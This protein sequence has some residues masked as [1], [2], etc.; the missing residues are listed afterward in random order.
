MSSTESAE[1][2]E[3]DESCCVLWETGIVEAF[4]N[5]D[6]ARTEVMA[7]ESRGFRGTIYE[8]LSEAVCVMGNWIPGIHLVP[9]NLVGNPAAREFAGPDPCAWDVRSSEL[10]LR[11]ILLRAESE[12]KFRLLIYDEDHY[13]KRTEIVE[14]DQLQ[15]LLRKYCTKLGQLELQVEQQ[16]QE[17][18]DIRQRLSAVGDE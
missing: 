10:K 12:N 2:E 3:E 8:Y 11:C 9:V 17:L 1:I 18:N 5:E 6:D 4:D 16:K 7:M 14:L 13:S 15:N